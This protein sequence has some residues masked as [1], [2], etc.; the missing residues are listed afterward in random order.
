MRTYLYED[1]PVEIIYA[2]VSVYWCFHAGLTFVS[3]PCLVVQA[4]VTKVA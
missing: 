3:P 4:V 1:V 2:Y